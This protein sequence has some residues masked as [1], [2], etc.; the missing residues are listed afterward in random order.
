RAGR[1]QG[2]AV[3]TL[4]AQFLERSGWQVI[5]RKQT[6]DSL[7]A[8]KDLARE[9]AARVDCLVVV[10]GDGTLREVCAALGP[11]SN[12]VLL[13]FIPV[14]NANVMARELGIP[15]DPSQAIRLLATGRPL[16]VDAALL[17]A[18][19]DSTAPTLFMAMLEIGFGA[20]VIHRVH[21]WRRRLW[22]Q[23][24]RLWGDSLYLMAGV[25]SLIGPQRPAFRIW[26]D[27]QAPLDQ[28][29]LAVIANTRTYAKGWSMNPR[30]S[31]TDGFLDVMCRQRDNT[32]ALVQ[33]IANAWR[34]RETRAPDVQYH[35]GRRLVVEADRPLWIQADGDPLPPQA[36]L[37][38]EILPQALQI[39]VP[40]QTMCSPTPS[41]PV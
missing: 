15:R 12:R 13:G 19:D 27:D 16:A 4:A 39:L 22:Q 34:S 28:C 18:D 32:P 20:L 6:P 5:D 17:T 3:G 33:N 40:A 38:V 26:I 36:R 21:H 31:A 1:G 11:F 14:G 29:R 7:S 8:R 37:R 35:K 9:L 25:L 30:A 10:G 41:A 2:G 24:Y 23:A